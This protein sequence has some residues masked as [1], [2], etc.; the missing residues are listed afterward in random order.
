MTG[1]LRSQE[2]RGL[3]RVEQRNR[4]ERGSDVAPIESE[5]VMKHPTIGTS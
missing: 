3:L 4:S 2:E 1:S 5:S